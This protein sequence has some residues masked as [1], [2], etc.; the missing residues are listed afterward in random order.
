MRIWVLDNDVDV[1]VRPVLLDRGQ[2][3]ETASALGLAAADDNE[4]AV[5]VDDMGG[6]LI[7][8][9]RRFGQ[10]RAGP[11]MFGRHV[12]LRCRESAAPEVLEFWMDQLLVAV[13]REPC[14]VEIR[15]EKMNTNYPGWSESSLGLTP[16]RRRRSRRS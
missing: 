5:R 9:D 3:V 4:L 12:Y 14:V 2:K 8:H 10:G 13:Q 7:S 6:V 11:S 15:P 1:A 16:K